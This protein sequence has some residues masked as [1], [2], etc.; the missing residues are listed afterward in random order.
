MEAWPLNTRGRLN[1]RIVIGYSPWVIHLVS[2]RVKW[3]LKI[4]KVWIDFGR[5]KF[6]DQYASMKNYV[7]RSAVLSFELPDAFLI[8]Y[9]SIDEEHQQIVARV[10]TLLDISKNG[11]SEV[12]EDAFESLIETVKAHFRH[13]E[14]LMADV[15]YDGL[16]W[17]AAHHTES[18]V[19]LRDLYDTC[20]KKGKVETADIFFCFDHVIKDVAKADLKFGEFLDNTGARNIPRD[21]RE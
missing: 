11:S 1:T 19:A 12:F 8:K 13:E 2:R 10:N 7:T 3:S 14:L 5:V 20:L 18:L 21:L 6:A 4:I 9:D 16:E 17:H 15:G